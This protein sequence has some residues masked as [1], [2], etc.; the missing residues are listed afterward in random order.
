MWEEV[1]HQKMTMSELDGEQL[2]IYLFIMIHI[3]K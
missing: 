1:D 3:N 2:V